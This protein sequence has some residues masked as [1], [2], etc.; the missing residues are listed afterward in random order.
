[1]KLKGG[2]S[3]LTWTLLVTILMGDWRR[4]PQLGN[5]AAQWTGSKTNSNRLYICV[6]VLFPVHFRNL[7]ELNSRSTTFHFHIRVKMLQRPWLH[8]PSSI[9]SFMYTAWSSFFLLFHLCGFWEEPLLLNL[10]LPVSS[11]W[12]KLIQD[13]IQLE[14]HL[15]INSVTEQILN[16]NLDF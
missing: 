16:L 7:T 9:I 5:W 1:M 11:Y 4:P 13:I 6:G 12:R 8:H 10:F 3:L 2:S 14:F 15:P